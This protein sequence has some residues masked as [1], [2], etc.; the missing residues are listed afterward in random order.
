[1]PAFAAVLT[2]VSL[3]SIGL[4]GT[5]GF[6][7]EFLVLLGAFQTYP[8][9]AG[10][11]TTG[12][13][14]AA[15]YLLWALQRVIYQKLDNPENE[16]LKDLSGREVAILAP[17]VLLIVWI[18]VYPKPILSRIDRS[19][20]S[21]VTQYQPGSRLASDRA[22]DAEPGEDPERPSPRASGRRGD[23]D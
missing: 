19:V 20:A 6:V 5:N 3:S 9:A 21:F 1:M 11:A 17:I 16:H 12:V 15:A 22:R 8:W 14:F 7:G 23:A 10:I 4:P 13:I 18:G 2:L